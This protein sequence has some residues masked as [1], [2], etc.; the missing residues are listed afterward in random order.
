VEAQVTLAAARAAYPGRRLVLAFQPHRYSR[1]RDL[2]EDFVKVLAAPDVLLLAEVYPAGEA[3]IVAA[4]GRA[5]ARA[6][7]AGGAVEPVFVE[8]I[9]DM[10][11]TI[12]KVARDGDV[13]LTMGAGSIGGVPHQL[14]SNQ[15]VAS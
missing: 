9:A 2:F 3:P 13:V 11:A 12:L 6:L 8:A 5:L 4:D 10:P 1:T 7:R 15:K 14:T